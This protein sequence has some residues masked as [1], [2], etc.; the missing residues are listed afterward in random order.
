LTTFT[1]AFR[2]S[3]TGS[4]R[5]TSYN[6]GNKILTLNGK[7][8]VVWLDAPATICGRTYDHQSKT[9]GEI[10]RID[11]GCDNHASIFY[12]DRTELAATTPPATSARPASA[13]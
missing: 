3:Q 11:D 6:W 9:W 2:L 1:E 12:P 13:I 10:V 7:T 5:A 4:T 8:H